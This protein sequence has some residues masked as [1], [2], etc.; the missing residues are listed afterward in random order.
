VAE[1]ALDE[2]GRDIARGGADAEGVAQ[3]LGHGHGAT[4]PGG[5]HNAADFPVARAARPIPEAIILAKATRKTLQRAHQGIGDGY[6]TKRGAPPLEGAKDDAL[7]IG[8]EMARGD[9]QRLA[10]ATARGGDQLAEQ[11]RCGVGR[12][13]R[14]V[15]ARKLRIAQIFSAPA[16]VKKLGDVGCVAHARITATASIWGIM[17]QG[18]MLKK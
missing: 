18:G 15:K 8:I 5:V 1:K 6:G 7:G 3:A 12:A 9:R 11:P 4:D 10:D 13:Q 14:L 17:L 2:V 16:A